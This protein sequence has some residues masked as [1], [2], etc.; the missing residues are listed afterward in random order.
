MKYNLHISQKGTIVFGQPVDL[1]NINTRIHTPN[2][3]KARQKPIDKQTNN[4]LSGHSSD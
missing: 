2:Q 1:C 3:T 4:N